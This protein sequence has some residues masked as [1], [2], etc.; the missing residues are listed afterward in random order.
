MLLHEGK[1]VHPVLDKLG[2][3]QVNDLLKALCKYQ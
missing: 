1:G 2:K 3:T